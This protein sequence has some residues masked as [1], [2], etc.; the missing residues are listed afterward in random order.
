MANKLFDHLGGIVTVKLRGRRLERILNLAIS[1]GIYLWDIKKGQDWMSFKI[2]GSGYE[3]LR[4]L[5]EEHNLNLE[6][7]NRKGLPFMKSTI[8]RRLGFLLGG[9]VFIAALYMLSSFVWF[10]SVAG[11]KKIDDQRILNI[12]AK[13]GIYQG[14]PKWSFDRNQAEEAMLKEMKE[15]TYVKV[16]IQGVRAEI[17]VVEKILPEQEI[18]APCHMVAQKDGI[19]EEVLVLEGQAN[20]SKGDAVARGDVLISGIVFPQPSP[21]IVTEGEP[22]LDPYL[23]RA[24]GMVKAKVWYEGYGECGLLQETTVNTGEKI[25]LIYMI[26]PWREFK[27]FGNDKKGF[28]LSQKERFQK[29][30][31]TPMGPIGFSKTI[32]KEQNIEVK[33]YTQKEATDIAKARAMQVLKNKMETPDKISDTRVEVLSSPGDSI[34]RMKISVETIEE[35]AAPSLLNKGENSN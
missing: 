11:N 26:T 9:V 16:D 15:L 24:R 25:E 10:I 35:I 6:V 30:V 28:E 27:I 4:G 2:R 8:S 34:L 29:V 17:Q 18:T 22:D 12:A 19:I 33:K 32:E 5:A 1:R 14:S 7:V 3:A 23:V 13:Y 31:N 21:Y 20:V